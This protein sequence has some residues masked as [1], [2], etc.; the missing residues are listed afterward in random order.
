MT[1]DKRKELQNWRAKRLPEDPPLG[2]DAEEISRLPAEGRF[3]TIEERWAQPALAVRTNRANLSQARGLRFKPLS[4]AVYPPSKQPPPMGHGPTDENFALAHVHG[5]GGKN[6]RGSMV[7]LKNGAVVYFAGAV[8]VV[9]RPGREGERQHFYRGHDDVITSIA[10][11]P[12]GKIVATG[13]GGS[14]PSVHIWDSDTGKEICRTPP[15]HEGRISCVSFSQ[16]GQQL[17]TVGEDKFHTVAAWAWQGMHQGK[18][19][20]SEKEGDQILENRVDREASATRGWFL[21]PHDVSTQSVS[22]QLDL[23]SGMLAK[24][25]I[26]RYYKDAG[27]A[28]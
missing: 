8:V 17:F 16:D 4:G 13:Q 22:P 9:R 23:F 12:E 10:V 15:F 21:K 11:H 1:Q 6:A 28:C 14:K 24:R 3:G 18:L 26:V 2:V 19:N 25:L 27:C 7:A 20:Y 5:A